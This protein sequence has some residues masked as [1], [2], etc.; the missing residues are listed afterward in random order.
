MG[1]LIGF[2]SGLLHDIFK[3]AWLRVLS[4]KGEGRE[5]VLDK[6]ATILGSGD[7]GQVDFGLYGDPSVAS[8]HAEI[9]KSGNTF[10]VASLGN[11]PIMVNSVPV[12]Q[13]AALRD[14]DRLQLGNTILV[15]Q[16][17]AES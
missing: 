1:F 4:G 3:R 8:R 15:F 17:R 9:R 7:I 16:S 12:S 5:L 11:A 2:F 14:G 13:T 10:T 6:R